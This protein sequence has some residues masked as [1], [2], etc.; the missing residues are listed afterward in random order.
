MKKLILLILVAAVTISPLANAAIS[1]STANPASPKTAAAGT[2]TVFIEE[3]TATW[4]PY[5]PAAAEGLHA[6]YAEET[7]HSFYYVADIYDMT[8]VAK[9]RFVNNGGR[10][11]P[12]IFLDGGFSSMTGTGQTLEQTK[13]AYRA[14]INDAGN[15]TVHELTIELSVTGHDDGKLEITQIVTNAGTR[16][17]LGIM[18]TFVAEKVSRWNNY[19]G[20]PYGFGTLDCIKKLVFIAPQKSVTIAKNW[21]GAAKHGNLTFTDLQDS[22]LFVISTLAHWRPIQVPAGEYIREHYAFFVDQT[23]GADVTTA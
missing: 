22:N 2:H 13:T 7:D 8:S 10:A 9:D 15:R 6:L 14:L 12:T 17:Y 5:C 16:P 18:R 4:C 1:N 19:D 23:A 21:D 20:D 11:F 3:G